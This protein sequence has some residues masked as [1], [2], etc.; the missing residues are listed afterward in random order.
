MKCRSFRQTRIAAIR[1]SEQFADMMQEEV[2]EWAKV[3]KTY[4][5]RPNGR[6]G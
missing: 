6:S 1:S 4:G 2:E 3:L 5:I